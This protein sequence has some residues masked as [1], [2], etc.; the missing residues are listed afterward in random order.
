MSVVSPKSHHYNGNASVKSMEL[1][2]IPYM[3][4]INLKDHGASWKQLIQF[5]NRCGGDQ[6][7][8]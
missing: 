1:S 4:D 5:R 2:G 8:F 6:W 7:G 3:S